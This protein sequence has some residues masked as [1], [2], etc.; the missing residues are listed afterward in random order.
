MNSIDNNKKKQKKII[1]LNISTYICE[2]GTL[3]CLIL[4]ENKGPTV[5]SMR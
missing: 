5:C 2:R 3:L 1:N 4:L